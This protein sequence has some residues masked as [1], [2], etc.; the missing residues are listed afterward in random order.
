MATPLPLLLTLSRQTL[1]LNQLELANLLR[2]SLRSVQRWEGKRGDP[3]HHQIQELA[4][5]VRPHDPDLA[6]QIDVWAPRPAPP[7]PPALV[8][9]PTESAG[10]PVLPPPAPPAPPPS[11]PVPAGVLVDSVV[12]AAAEAMALAP[13][14][15][16]PAVL[17]AFARARDA[18]LTMDAV[19]GV[20][21]PP[22]PPAPE[23]TASKGK[24]GKGGGR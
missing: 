7:P 2:T 3:Y 19:I 4:D 12:C 13:Q 22:P 24:G 20:L 14:A 17:A 1:H 11:P 15:T 8:P 23:P 6:S 16:R 10:P 5:A 21:A 9:A 18:G